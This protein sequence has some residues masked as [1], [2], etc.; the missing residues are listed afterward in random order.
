MTNKFFNKIKIKISIKITKIMHINKY[1]II[2]SL[3]YMLLKND[4]F[5]VILKYI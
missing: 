1:K 5:Q 4:Y 2:N 3:K